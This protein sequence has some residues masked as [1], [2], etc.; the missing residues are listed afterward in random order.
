MRDPGVF[1]VGRGR[2]E[3]TGDPVLHS[4]KRVTNGFQ[5]AAVGRLS[6]FGSENMFILPRTRLSVT[7]LLSG[8]NGCA[9]EADLWR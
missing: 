1:G 4:R 7:V 9:D 6:H 2:R 5:V 8:N 3:G